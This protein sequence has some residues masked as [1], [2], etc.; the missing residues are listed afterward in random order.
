MAD[1]V[2][3]AE[4]KQSRYERYIEE[5]TEDITNT[6]DEF[7]CQ[8]ILFVG[9]GLTKRYMDAPNW[10]ELLG[11]LADKCSTINK[12]LGFYK[13]S[14]GSAIKIG[15]E[16]ARLYHEW[17]WGAGNNEF[18]KEMFGDNVHAQSY[19]KFKIAEYL[20]SLNP[21]NAKG[22][23]EEYQAEIDVLSKVKPHAIITTNYDQM[24]ELIF[25]D[26]EPIIGQQILKGQQVCIG[27]IYKIHGCVTAHDSIVF[28]EDDYDEFMKRKKFLSAKLLTFFNEHPLVFVGY[29]A[30]DPNIRA[31]L[32]DIDEAL[33]EKGGIIPNVYILQWDDAINDDSWPQREKVIP[34]EEDRSVRVK[35]IVAKD[36]SWVFDAFAANPA[37]AHVNTRVLRSLIARSYELV[38][39]DIPKMTV[40]ADFKML[41]D[42]VETPETFAKL[43]G[44]ANIHD[45]SAAGAYH[46]F[47]LTQVGQ[48]LGHK[49]WHPADHLITRVVNEKGV[50]IK[51][52]DNRYHRAD[53]VNNTVFH[54]YSKDAIDLLKKVQSNEEYVL[55]LGIPEVKKAE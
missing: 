11:H 45:Y 36:F 5:I 32:S 29:N 53:K 6:V 24:L 43:F 9:S 44:I 21:G 27:E 25:P 3:A 22:L 55:D 51:K 7:G 2:A 4:E 46:R 31:I 39:H 33:P 40:E 14:L 15:Q 10:E 48:A 30:G 54:K 12:G 37:L 41:N 42:A 52:S 34:T 20:T 47:S 23:K 13:Q 28:T 16:F 19:I 8:P 38:R 1:Q 17:A 50:N 49:N 35:M 18:P 26:H